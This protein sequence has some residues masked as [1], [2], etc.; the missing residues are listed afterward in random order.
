ML[1][2]KKSFVLIRQTLSGYKPLK[3]PENLDIE[4]DR[5][6]LS[7]LKK[8]DRDAVF[9]TM[10][11]STTAN[12]ISFLKWPMT[13]AQ[14]AAICSESVL[15]LSWK[16]G[17]IFLGRNRADS[18]PVGCVGLALDE[19][20]CKTAEVGYWVTENWQGCGCAT[21]ML[22]AV[23]EFAFNPPCHLT[24]LVGYVSADNAKSKRLLKK[25]GF[26]NIGSKKKPTAKGTKLDFY[27][28]ELKNPHTFSTIKT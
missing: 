28:Y 3:L 12:M 22:K 13:K 7:P 15:G 6:T 1:L 11:S 21:E 2:L 17:I 10:N 26:K 19:N 8:E 27:I 18:F 24:R 14:A 4:T 25:Q 20:D 9:V 23:I 5:F 16:R